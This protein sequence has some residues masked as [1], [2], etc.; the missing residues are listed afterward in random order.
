MN[1]YLVG[2]CRIPKHLSVFIGSRARANRFM[3]PTTGLSLSTLSIRRRLPC[4]G[5]CAS[6]A[7]YR[8]SPHPKASKPAAP[9]DF[10][11]YRLL[12]KWQ[13]EVFPTNLAWLCPTM[14]ATFMLDAMSLSAIFQCAL[15]NIIVDEQS[16]LLLGEWLRIMGDRSC[17]INCG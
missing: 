8:N 4:R 5:L 11:K 6:T 9:M 10:R 16:E 14:I 15:S 7:F 13:Q 12:S 17:A 3:F 1:G 2:F